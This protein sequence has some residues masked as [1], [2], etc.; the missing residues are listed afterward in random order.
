MIS[1]FLSEGNVGARFNV[2][3][4][5]LGGGWIRPDNSQLICH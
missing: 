3:C 1:N 2:R 5:S 4:V